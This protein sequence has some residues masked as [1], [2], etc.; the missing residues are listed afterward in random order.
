MHFQESNLKPR[1][2]AKAK[3]V[4][5]KL[6]VTLTD[7]PVPKRDDDTATL[8]RTRVVDSSIRDF[9]LNPLICPKLAA[10]FP[11]LALRSDTQKG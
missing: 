9:K 11:S 5:G 2:Q 10:K 3:M 7:K 8:C 4:R 6:K 1:R